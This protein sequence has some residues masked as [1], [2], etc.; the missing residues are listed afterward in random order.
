MV[1]ACDQTDG[2]AR[3]GD[4]SAV[5]GQAW[6]HAADEGSAPPGVRGTRV[7]KGQFTRGKAEAAGG[8]RKP[9]GRLTALLLTDQRRL[10]MWGLV[11]DA[12]SSPT[13]DPRA[14]TATQQEPQVARV[15]GCSVHP[16]S[17]TSRSDPAAQRGGE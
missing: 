9:G 11:I 2:G 12:L 4:C 7:G 14:A 6:V 10:P 5:N 13:P 16:H 8:V 15:G 3:P 1:N 17:S